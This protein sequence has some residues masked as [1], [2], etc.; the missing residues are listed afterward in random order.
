MT[1]PDVN[2]LQHFIGHAQRECL[3]ELLTGEEGAFFANK[4]ATLADLLAKM[5]TTYTQE[6]LGDQAIIHLHYFKAGADWYITEK[7]ID[8]DGEGQIQAFGLV[9]LGYGPEVGYISIPE[10]LE[11]GA[12]LDLYFTPITLAAIINKKGLS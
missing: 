3:A 2:T 7:D 12:E 6:S 10:I 5:P 11:Q 4:L 8:S 9:N 1:T